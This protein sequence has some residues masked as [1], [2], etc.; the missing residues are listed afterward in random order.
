[1]KQ[2]TVG[3]TAHVDSGKTTLAEALLFRTGEIRR[4]GRVD[5]GDSWLDT[6]E[7]EKNRHIR[8]TRAP[9]PA[10]WRADSRDRD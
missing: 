6:D 9:L 7:I 5:R 8:L 1:M 10:S 4:L 3:L 2:L